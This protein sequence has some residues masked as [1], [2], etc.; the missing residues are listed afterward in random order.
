MM[1]NTGTGQ[2]HGLQFSSHEVVPEKRTA[3][4]LTGNS[5]FCLQSKME[6]SFEFNFRPGFETY[7]GYIV[8]IIAVPG[9]TEKNRQKENIDIVYNQRLRNFNFVV[10]ENSSNVFDIDSLS[11][12]TKWNRIKIRFDL[13]KQQVAL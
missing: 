3:L 10:D 1:I 13:E 5:P 9:Q 11:L 7:F 6:L 8:R 12:H 4:D 2:S